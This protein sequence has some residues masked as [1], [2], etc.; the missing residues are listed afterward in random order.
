MNYKRLFTWL[1]AVVAIFA[2]NGSLS[3]QEVKECYAFYDSDNATTGEQYL[4]GKGIYRFDFDGTKMTNVRLY[5]SL[6]I[7]R[8]SGSCLIDGVYYWFDYS[9]SAKGHVCNGFYSFDMETGETRQIANYGGTQGGEGKA[10]GRKGVL[11]LPQQ[12]AAQ[13]LSPL[14]RGCGDG[15][16]VGPRLPLQ[17]HGDPARHGGEPVPVYDPGVLLR[18]KAIPEGAG[19]LRP[20]AEDAPPQGLQWKQLRLFCLAADHRLTSGFRKPRNFSSSTSG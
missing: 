20:V 16:D 1:T 10:L 6:G 17:R 2:W 3:A 5:R 7:D 15:V 18:G 13:A 9:Q 8:A 19:E 14:L 11:Q 12:G 4:G